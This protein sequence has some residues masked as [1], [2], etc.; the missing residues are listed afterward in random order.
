MQ[1]NNQK[2]ALIKSR[3]QVHIIFEA[4]NS[5][6]LFV[7]IPYLPV[8]NFS[9][10]ISSLCVAHPWQATACLRMVA[11][12]QQ[13]AIRKLFQQNYKGLVLPT[14]EKGRKNEKTD[15]IFYRRNDNVYP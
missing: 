12:T 9:T 13:N 7:L 14:R 5:C 8:E 4:S 11:M 15:K 1:I 6:P 2:I 3:E 10:I